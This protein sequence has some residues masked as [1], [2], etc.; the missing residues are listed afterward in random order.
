MVAVGAGRP[1][2]EDI[3]QA[4]AVCPPLAITVNE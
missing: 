3:R 4:A 1:L 2:S